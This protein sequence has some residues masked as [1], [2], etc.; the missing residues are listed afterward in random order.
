MNVELLLVVLGSF[1]SVILAINGFLLRSIHAD[2]GDVKVQMATIFTSSGSRE[3][4]LTNVEIELFKLRENFHA[5]NTELHHLKSLAL[6][7]DKVR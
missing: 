5:I 7:E 2:L 4:R 1:L 6:F 3:V